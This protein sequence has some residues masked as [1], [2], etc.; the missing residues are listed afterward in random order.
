[1]NIKFILL[2][3]PLFYSCRTIDLENFHGTY[4]EECRRPMKEEITFFKNGKF[5][6]EYF[7][8]TH[9]QYHKGDFEISGNQINL[10]FDSI[11]TDSLILIKSNALYTDSCEL[12]LH[13][14]DFCFNQNAIIFNDDTIV[15]QGL[16]QGDLLH[17]HIPRLSDTINIKIGHYYNNKFSNN[18]YQEIKIYIKEYS[19]CEFEYYPSDSWYKFNQPT[20]NKYY[21]DRKKN[22]VRDK[23]YKYLCYKKK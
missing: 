8:D 5:E 7:D 14:K 16:M 20:T 6:I 17:V 9:G 2:L 12:K 21:I 10:L 22:I 3:F 1:M 13:L 18:N 15:T 11:Y 19:Y 4:T 23:N